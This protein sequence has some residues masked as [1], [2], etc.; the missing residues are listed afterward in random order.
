MNTM[1]QLEAAQVAALMTQHW[2]QPELTNE[3]FELLVCALM[4]SPLAKD[5]AVA[6]LR[7]LMQE[8]HKFRPQVGDLRAIEPPRYHR[9]YLVAIDPPSVSPTDALAA[10]REARNALNHETGATS[11]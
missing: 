3:G 10:L 1:T 5:Q 2:P 4:D 9:P 11:A 7:K 8:I 6:A